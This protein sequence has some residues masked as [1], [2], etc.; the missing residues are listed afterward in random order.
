M[1]ANGHGEE[2]VWWSPPF[3]VI[4]NHKN[5]Y[6]VMTMIMTMMQ[7]GTY[8]IFS[9]SPFPS[10]LPIAIQQIYKIIARLDDTVP[11]FFKSP[12]WMEELEKSC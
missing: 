3:V 10:P 4:D 7:P 2:P 12:N 6:M 1:R 9:L 8:F 11:E 5:G